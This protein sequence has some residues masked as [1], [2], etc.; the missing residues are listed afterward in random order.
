M[1]VRTEMPVF[2]DFDGRTNVFDTGCRISTRTSAGNLA[3]R[4]ALW[5]A[6]EFL[7]EILVSSWVS[8]KPLHLNSLDGAFPV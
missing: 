8:L 4:L 6:F 5:A 7:N 3:P 2:Q 1:D